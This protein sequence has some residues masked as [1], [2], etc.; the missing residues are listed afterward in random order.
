[1]ETTE[2]SIVFVQNLYDLG[3]KEVV[4]IKIDDYPEGQNAGKTGGDIAG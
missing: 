1:M 3:A 2:D 4:A